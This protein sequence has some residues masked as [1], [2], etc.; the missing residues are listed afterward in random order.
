MADVIGYGA[1]SLADEAREIESLVLR[2]WL[3]FPR[4]WQG[5]ISFSIWIVAAFQFARARPHTTVHTLE[6]LIERRWREL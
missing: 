5:R 3:T 6:W 2:A 1:Q 4:T